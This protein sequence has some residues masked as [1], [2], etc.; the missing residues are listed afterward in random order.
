MKT[1]AKLGAISLVASLALVGCGSSSSS[2]DAS[3]QGY[4]IDSAVSGTSYTT[5]SGISGITDAQGGFKYREGDSVKFSLGKVVLGESTPATDGLITPKSLIAGDDAPTADQERSIT[6]LLQTLQSL[7]SDNDPSNGITIDSDVLTALDSLSVTTDFDTLDEADLISLDNQHDLGLDEDFD[8]QLD[9][10]QTQARGHFDD[11]VSDWEHGNRPDTTG[12]TTQLH[13][14]TATGEQHQ[15]GKNDEKGSG[16]S[17]DCNS[18]SSNSSNAGFDINNYPQTSELSQE[19]KDALAHMGNEERLAYDVY[20]NLYNYHLSSSDLSIAQLKNISQKSEITHVG[21]VQDIVQKYNLQATDLSDVDGAVA[22]GNSVTFEEMKSGV[23]DI[24]AIQSLYNTL[25][26][27]GIQ[28][29][30]DALKVG[31][32]V[33]VVDINDL[34]EYVALAEESNATDVLAAFDVLRDGSY[35]HYWAFDKGLKNLGVENGC[36]V[37]GDALLGESKEGIY[38]TNTH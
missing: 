16:G 19:L 12:T 14:G 4:F 28:S 25:Y 11:S 24:E 7:D 31:C 22:Q 38:P 5:S 27:L 3:L 21:I 26:D 6:L 29:Q 20:T 35:N 30:T 23:Y 36:Y 13:D 32:M 37:E 34:D 17:G 18:T 15:Y 1:L 33:E 8:G 2:S 9:V 10:N